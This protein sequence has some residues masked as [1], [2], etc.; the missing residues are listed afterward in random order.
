[1]WEVDSIGVTGL[2]PYEP[3]DAVLKHIGLLVRNF[4]EID[5]ILTT[6]LALCAGVEEVKILLLLGQSTTRRKSELTK[7]F[8]AKAG[9][10][11][12]ILY[13]ST[14]GSVAF[15]EVLS[16]RNDVA[17]GTIAGLTDKGAIAF[18][19]TKHAGFDEVSAHFKATAYTEDALGKA[20]Y[21]ST[22][23]LKQLN[24]IPAL[25]ASR[26]KRAQQLLH[27]HPANP[28]QAKRKVKPKPPRQ[29]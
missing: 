28:Q 9:L 8:S 20:A 13:K 23:I 18:L 3:S 24:T 1:M 22:I 26:E 19:T 5:S 27:P 7:L 16:V 21:N 6:F 15:E 10:D 29:P 4:A 2:T 25:R 14:F 11:S 17:H 12:Q